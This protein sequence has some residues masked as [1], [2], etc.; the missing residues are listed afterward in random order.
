VAHEI[1]VFG[2]V[3]ANLFLCH[4]GYNLYMSLR[5]ENLLPEII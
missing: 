4:F 2:N 3:C 5:L 1:L